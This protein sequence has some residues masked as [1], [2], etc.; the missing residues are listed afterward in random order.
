MGCLYL[1]EHLAEQKSEGDNLVRKSERDSVV[2][3]SQKA[4]AGESDEESDDE[5]YGHRHYS[6]FGKDIPLVHR[7]HH[8]SSTRK[9]LPDWTIAYDDTWR[10]LGIEKKL[11]L[12]HIVSCL[13]RKRNTG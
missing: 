10:K 9:R 8:P 12:H 1:T 6:P 13:N 7:N 5:D 4:T 2:H 3:Q 11:D